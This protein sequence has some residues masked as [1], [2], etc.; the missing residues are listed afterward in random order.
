[1]DIKG[2]S[3]IDFTITCNKC[4]SDDV[5]FSAQEDDYNHIEMWII[6]RNCDN[7]AELRQS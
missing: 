7:D 3:L 5:A 2:E 1:M 6:C 4:E